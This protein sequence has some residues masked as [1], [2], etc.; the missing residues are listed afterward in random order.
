[1]SA[2]RTPPDGSLPEALRRA[3]AET[4]RARRR[5]RRRARLLAGLVVLLGLAALGLQARLW[6]TLV[7]LPG[8]SAAEPRP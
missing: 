5:R 2:G 4:N 8:D 3:V 7:A 1:M 6:W